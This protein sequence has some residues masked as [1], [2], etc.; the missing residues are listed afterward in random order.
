MGEDKQPATAEEFDAAMTAIVDGA[1]G[2]TLTDEEVT[3]YE[4]LE[5][6]IRLWT[7]VEH[8]IR[9]EVAELRHN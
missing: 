5:A 8:A 6:R 7:E 3:S 2:R 4:A 1:K 9:H